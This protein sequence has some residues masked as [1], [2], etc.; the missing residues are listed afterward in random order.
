V[1]KCLDNLSR[2]AGVVANIVTSYVLEAERFG[3][4]VDTLR[5]FVKNAGFKVGNRTLRKGLETLTSLGYLRKRKVRVYRGKEFNDV[6][7]YELTE[8]FM[9]YIARNYLLRR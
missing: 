9:T 8:E 7:C 6:D 2:D 3:F 1:S 5:N 4:T